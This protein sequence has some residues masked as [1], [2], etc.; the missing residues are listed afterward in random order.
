LVDGKSID[1]LV[2]RSTRH[3]SHEYHAD[4][5]YELL[6]NQKIN[7]HTKKVD[8]DRIVAFQQRQLWLFNGKH[9]NPHQ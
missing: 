9:P 2:K 5:H 8:Y 3:K 1:D 7:T 4:V 6:K